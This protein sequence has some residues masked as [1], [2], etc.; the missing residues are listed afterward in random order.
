[1]SHQTATTPV[2]KSTE[3][4]KTTSKSSKRSR[5]TEK[6]RDEID[7][8]RKRTSESKSSSSNKLTSENRSTSS[9]SETRRSGNTSSRD[10]SSSRKHK[11]NPETKIS[12]TT[13]STTKSRH[14]SDRREE[15]SSERRR[16]SSHRIRP[17]KSLD[18]ITDSDDHSEETAVLKPTAAEIYSTMD[19]SLLSRD[20]RIPLNSQVTS[21]ITRS[22]LNG[23]TLESLGIAQRLLTDEQ[24]EK[25]I[26]RP[27]QTSPLIYSMRQFQQQSAGTILQSCQ[28]RFGSCAKDMIEMRHKWF[29]R[30]V[31]P[32]QREEFM[33]KEH[34]VA[35]Q[36]ATNSL[37]NKTPSDAANLPIETTSNDVL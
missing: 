17:E 16:S 20:K 31:E 1:L 37:L 6:P 33:N 11:E 26:D 29:I 8:K 35:F 24:K 10:D 4:E 19:W 30:S 13:S 27:C 36:Q 2:K 5:E 15:T 12:R 14:N 23:Q 9:R 18:N 28:R 21:R 25:L 22:K 32:I 34:Y 7:T 3:N